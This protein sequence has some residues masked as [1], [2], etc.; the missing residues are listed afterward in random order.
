MAAQVV[1]WVLVDRKDLDKLL[2]TAATF[3][4]ALEDLFPNTT[5]AREQCAEEEVKA[6]MTEAPEALEM[7]KE[8]AE[9]QDR[10]LAHWTSKAP[11]PRQRKCRHTIL[12]TITAE[13]NREISRV[14]HSTCPET[15]MS[16]RLRLLPSLLVH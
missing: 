12:A 6:F 15:G 2:N 16:E 1:P 7:L 14:A 11:T 5:I 8:L 13:F 9:K 10:T 4:Q 3:I